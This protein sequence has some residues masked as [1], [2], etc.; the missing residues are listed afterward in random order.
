MA[1]EKATH[2][3][4]RAALQHYPAVLAAKAALSRKRG[5]DL[6]ALETWYRSDLAPALQQR[7]RQHK[8]HVTKEELQQLMQWKLAVRVCCLACPVH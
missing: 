2:T 4:L 5:Y 7:G 3:A 8:A 6:E 1:P